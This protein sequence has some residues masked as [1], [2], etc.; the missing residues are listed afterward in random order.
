MVNVLA[1]SAR[2]VS[3]CEGMLLLLA[4]KLFAHIFGAILAFGLV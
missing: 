4:L 1:I 2:I 3:R